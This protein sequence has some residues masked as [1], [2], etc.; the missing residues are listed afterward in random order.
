[1]STALPAV[2]GTIARIVFVGQPCACATRDSRQRGSARGQMQKSSTGKF[3]G[4][5]S[6][7]AL[8][9]FRTHG[10]RA[11]LPAIQKSSE[12][13]DGI[14]P[15]DGTR[16]ANWKKR[17]LRYVAVFGQHSDKQRA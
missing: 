13:W 9:R 7:Q 16:A 12:V 2:N 11:S 15:A 17:R 6:E 4:G 14:V 3:H 10:D 8:E 5:S 1:M